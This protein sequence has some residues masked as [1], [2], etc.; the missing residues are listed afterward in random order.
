MIYDLEKIDLITTTKDNPTQLCLEIADEIQWKHHIDEHLLLLQEKLNNYVTFVLNKGYETVVPDK[1]FNAFVIKI[2]FA[3][4]P[5]E[6]AK[7]FLKQYQNILKNDG[8]AISI[9]YEVIKPD[10]E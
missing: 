7:S 4:I 5:D 1:V 10:Y 3:Y 2:N 9:S 8:I 6:K